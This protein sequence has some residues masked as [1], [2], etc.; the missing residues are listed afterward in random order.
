MPDRLCTAFFRAG[1]QMKAKNILDSLR[2]DGIPTNAVRCLQQK[3]TGETLISFTTA[4]Y[5]CKFLDNSAFFVCN[6]GYRHGYL[7]H[8]AAGELTFVTVYDAPYEMPDSAIE[9]CLKPYC[10]V[11]TRCRGRLQGYSVIN[12]GFNGI[13]VPNS[14]PVFRAIFVLGNS[15]FAS[16]MMGSRKLIEGV[17]LPIILPVIVPTKSASTVMELAIFPSP[18]QKR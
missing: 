5:C 10:T 14:S 18:V 9:E 7:A 11:Y 3:P 6:Q 12:N 1:P 2:S 4:G 8:P 16:I 13:F 15:N 17:G